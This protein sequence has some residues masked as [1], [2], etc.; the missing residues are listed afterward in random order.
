MHFLFLCMLIGC[1]DAK[2]DTL[3][4]YTSKHFVAAAKDL[5][6]RIG[7]PET[8]DL[9]SRFYLNGFY[10]SLNIPANARLLDKKPVPH[11]EFLSVVLCAKDNGEYVTWIYNHEIGGCVQ[12]H[13]FANLK[14]AAKDFEER[15]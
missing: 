6:T 11:S 1:G 12:G 7:V 14:D 8:Q 4:D 13:Y 2:K 5:W 10:Q 3:N 15:V 9:L